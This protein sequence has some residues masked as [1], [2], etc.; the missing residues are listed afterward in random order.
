MNKNSINLSAL[1]ASYNS[2]RAVQFTSDRQFNTD[3]YS[4]GRF[5]SPLS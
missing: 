4:R 2:D 3:L 1:I 5:I